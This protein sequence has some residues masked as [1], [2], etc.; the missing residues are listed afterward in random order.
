MYNAQ[1]FCYPH[2]V[3]V[4]LYSNIVDNSEVDIDSR[5]DIDW[6]EFEYVFRKRKPI[7]SKSRGHRDNYAQNTSLTNS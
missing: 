7:E 1:V 2:G 5:F 4:R 3:Q 6:D